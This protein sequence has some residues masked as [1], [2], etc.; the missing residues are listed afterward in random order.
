MGAFAF[1]LLE[2]LQGYVLIVMGHTSITVNIWL[3]IVL[4]TL[5]LL[6]GCL[7]LWVVFNGT[8]TLVKAVNG[9]LFGRAHKAQAR[10]ISGLNDFIEG[11]WK[12][13]RRKL[14]KAAP[15]AP[16]PLVNYLAAARSAFELGDRQQ[17]SQ[18]LH[19]AETL[20]PKSG[21]AVALTQARIQLVDGKF[22]QC[23]A[24]LQRGRREAPRHP[25]VLDLLRQAY[26]ALNDWPNLEELLPDLERYQVLSG[27]ALKT[28]QLQVYSARLQ[29]IGGQNQSSDPDKLADLNQFWQSLS[30]KQHKEP[31]LLLCYVTQLQQLAEHERAE[32]L[33]RQSLNANWTSEAALAYG[34]VQTEDAKQPLLVAESWLKE[35]RG[36]LSCCYH[37]GVWPCAMSYGAKRASILSRV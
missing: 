16:L 24:T 23:I 20:S 31:A 37:W 22:E 10:T 11:N 7:L 1:R 27:D 33:L 5:L 19:K 13:A 2:Q 34:C 28:L 12:A 3:A 30:R 15:T 32:Q 9:L 6:L 29:Q 8:R 36:M 21:L 4:Q 14:L 26:L 35:R 17:V 18:L 25:V